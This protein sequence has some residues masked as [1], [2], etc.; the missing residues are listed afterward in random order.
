MDA[1]KM[2]GAGLFHI[3]WSIMLPL[4]G[5]GLSALG[6]FTFLGSWN[7]FYGPLLYLQS[8]DKFTVPLGITLLQGFMSRGN[9]SMILAAVMMS[10]VPVLI[11]YLV[12][13]RYVVQGMAL[14]GTKR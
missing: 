8:F 9:R 14:T 12:A 3:Y 5:P 1:A 10:L 2:D 4:V 6:T 11:V 7:S 13:Q